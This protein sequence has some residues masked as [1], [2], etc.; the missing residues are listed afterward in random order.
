MGRTKVARNV[1]HEV[2]CL[3]LEGD[4]STALGGLSVEFL[5]MLDAGAWGASY[6][7][8]YHLIQQDQYGEQMG[9]I[10]CATISSSSMK[11]EFSKGRTQE[12]EQVHLGGLMAW[13]P[14]TKLIVFLQTIYRSRVFNGW[15][16]SVLGIDGDRCGE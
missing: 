12:T 13:M 6:V 4:T 14:L 15:S 11:L 3:R 8:P 5:C 16:S 2:E 10:S 1:D 9:E 7:C